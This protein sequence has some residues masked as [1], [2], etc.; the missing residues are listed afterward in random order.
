MIVAE[1]RTVIDNR[2]GN[3]VA[4]ALHAFAAYT[5]SSWPLAIATGYFDLGGYA[6][7]ENVLG[8]A[9]GV[10]ILLGTEPLPP[11][12]TSIP[13]PGEADSAESPR[14]LAEA[15]LTSLAIDRDLMPFAEE[16][17]SL[18]QRFC[19]FLQ[20]ED[21]EVRIHRREFLHG[22]AFIFG[23]EAGVVAGSANFT[24][25]GLTQN[26]ELDLGQYG[27]DD[28]RKVRRWFDD[29]WDQADP[30][31]LGA[32]YAG[33]DMDVDPYTIYLRMLLELYGDELTG[34]P[35]IVEHR[36]GGLSFAEFQKLGIERSRRILREWGG[37]ILADGVGLGKTFMAGGLLQHYER[38]L[39]L[40]ALV[41]APAGLRDAVWQKFCAKYGLSAQVVSFQ[42]LATDVQV[43]EPPGDGEV[44]H[45]KRNLL[46]D[47]DDYRLIVVDEAHAFRN[48]DTLYYR[49]LRRLIGRGGVSRHLVMLTATPVNNSLWDL[50]H[51]TLLFARHDAAFARIGIV[52]LRD[53]FREAL[54]LDLEDLAPNHLFPLL[55]AVSVRRT[56]HH[57]E[58]YYA[59]EVIET[60]EGPKPIRFPTPVLHRVDYRLDSL[61]PGY[62]PHVV[63]VIDNQLSMARYIPDAYRHVPVPTARQELL[64]GLLRSQLLKRFES[65]VAAF[66]Q[67]L[68][69]LIASQCRF[70]ELLD[71]G[72]V[73]S[74]EA[75]DEWLRTD[76]DD[77]ALADAIERQAEG[78]TPVSEY[79]VDDLR[80]AVETDRALLDELL[81]VAEA[82]T[83][84]RDPK[85]QAFFDLLAR[86]GRAEPGD[87]R[88]VVA[89]SYYADTV[90]YLAE[91]V[92][93]HAEDPRLS[94][95]QDRWTWVVG[96]ASHVAT[97]AVAAEDRQRAVWGFVP[98]SSVAPDGT[99]DRYDLL[100][101]TDVLAEGQNLQQC[102]KVVNLDL[103]WNPMRIVQR[104]GRVDRIGSPH[105]TVHLYCF[106]PAAEL[107]ALLSLE[108]RL[109]V[110]I[111]QANASVGTESAV[112]PGMAAVIRDFADVETQ[113][114]RIS[115]EDA[116][117]IDSLEAAVD[118]FSGETFREELRRALMADRLDELRV[119]PWK[120]GSGL[121]KEKLA[122]SVVFAA[123]IGK[124]PHWRTVPLGDSDISSDLLAQLAAV[125]CGPEEARVLVDEVKA[126]LF[127]LWEQAREAILVD[128][129]RWADPAEREAAVPAAQR[130]AV[131][132][133]Q[134]V[135]LPGAFEAV[136]TLQV[137]W[138]Q[139]IVRKIRAI[140]RRAEEGATDQAIAEDLIALLRTEGLRPP[141]RSDLPPAITADDIHL[142]CYQAVTN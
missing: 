53:F 136:A 36:P 87:G 103:P 16:T 27:P 55:D 94:A 119:L 14:D 127:D 77:E 85:L 92:E 41:V 142:V 66:R 67:T 132:L 135:D 98:R 106:F 12:R 21:V 100:L 62:V 131:T 59:G 28:V 38:D 101:T 48:P 42:E 24:R 73:A 90:A 70:I 13:L 52:H 96:D 97:T 99:E 4:D 54:T 25:K 93:A 95:Y 141:E 115:E 34:E 140:L 20:R 134:G 72:A 26:L 123:R 6:S 117:V 44:D 32:L 33:L 15:T 121:R 31:D 108:R 139:T 110:K 124:A 10:R 47:A 128:Y 138:P 46:L 50:Y 49:A 71:G 9:P 30:Y 3:T 113:I 84:E 65:S 75:S 11:R 19:T 111:A 109:R 125:G 58:K 120:V 102:G 91:Q 126:R 63:D 23:D 22:K 2:D 5:S 112:L 69:H 8:A 43:G 116:S 130:D 105:D 104:N 17:A 45:R 64:A 89:F 29:L 107:D 129:Q 83:P 1:R 133:L 60:A 51:Q 39:G 86:L 37:V 114:E 68:R 80:G 81:R 118:A 56:R 78:L 74:G 79:R 76:V 57:V 82:V 18:A 40:R 122:P 7:V 137:P 61:D 35:E 88:K